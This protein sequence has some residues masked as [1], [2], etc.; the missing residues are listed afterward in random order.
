LSGKYF[1]CVQ[2]LTKTWMTCVGMKCCVN[3]IKQVG[4]SFKHILVINAL[5]EYL[6]SQ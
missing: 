5:T 4:V 3:T 6:L 2:L 1:V